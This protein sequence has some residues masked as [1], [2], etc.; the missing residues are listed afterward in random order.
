LERYLF[1]KFDAWNVLDLDLI[2]F[3]Y[4]QVPWIFLYRDPIEVLVSQ[5]GHRGAHMV[6]GVIDPRLFGMDLST[7]TT[8]APEEY[9]AR[10]LAAVCE[11]AIHEYRHGGKLINYSELPDVV[12]TSLA[13]FF[14]LTLAQPEVECLRA[15]ADR[16]A[17]NPLVA[18]EEDASQKQKK[19]TRAVREAATKWLY[20]VYEKLEKARLMDQAMKGE[21]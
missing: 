6:P 11:G 20:P 1:V 16:D 18:F 5:L 8:I 15:A 12:W 7:A 21:G 19:A 2:R 14:G 13:D 4:P 9:C 3:A 10:V 17:K